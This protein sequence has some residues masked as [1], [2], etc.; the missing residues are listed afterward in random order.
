MSL[1]KRKQMFWHVVYSIQF[2]SIFFAI[3]ALRFKIVIDK[4]I[5]KKE[6]WAKRTATTHTV[7]FLKN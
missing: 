2:N 4:V 3:K 6:T 1:I 5:A 7:K